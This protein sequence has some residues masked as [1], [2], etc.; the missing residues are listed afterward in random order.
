MRPGRGNELRRG[1]QAPADNNAGNRITEVFFQDFLP[2]FR[3][4]FFQVSHFHLTDELRAL[5]GEKLIK[6][7]EL[8]AGPVQIG[9][10]DI[11]FRPG[12]RTQA[13]QVQGSFKIPGRNHESTSVRICH[14]ENPNT[15]SV[16]DFHRL[17]Y[18]KN[19]TEC[20]FFKELYRYK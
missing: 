9:R 6:S 10:T 14:N 3:R 12:R 5:K 13:F 8:H 2:G 19:R 7:A 15:L 16:N 11:P 17:S 20:I 18:H 1:S 4:L